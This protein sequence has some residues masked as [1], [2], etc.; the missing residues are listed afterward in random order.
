MAIIG[1]CKACG[2]RVS[3][4][5]AA[6]P[7]CGQPRPYLALPAEGSVH[8]ARIDHFSSGEYSDIY[9]VRLLSGIRGAASRHNRDGKRFAV[10]SDIK[11]RVARIDHG[12]SEVRFE[13]DE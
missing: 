8:H 9:V 11:V 3:D 4:E 1:Q 6:C 5:A 12:S 13:A 2:H 10:G 7:G